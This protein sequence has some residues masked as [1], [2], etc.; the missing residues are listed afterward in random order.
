M[1][2]ISEEKLSELVEK[3]VERLANEGGRETQ[4][5]KTPASVNPPFGCDPLKRGERTQSEQGAA[6]VGGMQGAASGSGARGGLGRGVFSDLDSAVSSAQRAFQSYQGMGLKG[7]FA[8]IA[9]MR[10]RAHR[11]VENI[12]RMAVEETGLGR[13]DQKLIK[14]R[15]V[16]DKTPGPEI[17]DPWAQTGD[18]G[19]MIEEYAP[20]GIIGAIAPTTNPT[21]TVICNAIG[22]LAAGNAVIFNAH[23]SAKKVSAYTVQFLNEAIVSAG[24]PENLICCTAEP[25]IE[26][27]QQLMRHPGIRLLVVT[28]GPGVVKEAMNSGK[29]VIAAGPGNPPAVVDDSADLE[30]AAEGLVKGIS[31]DNN[32]V[33]TAEKEIIA[34]ASIADE[35]KRAMARYGAY[36]VKGDELTRLEKLIVVDGHPNKKF[37]GKDA[38]V[39]LKEIGVNAPQNTLIAYAEV[40]E[41]HPFVQLELLTPVTGLVRVRNVDDAIA[42]AVRCEH[43]NGHT[44]C[45]YSRNIAALHAMACVINTSIFTKNAPTYAGLGLG[46]EGY[47]SFTISSPTGEGLT[48]ARHFSRRRRCTLKDYFRIV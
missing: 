38:A 46:G 35:L 10:E 33:C 31:L 37:V 26:L 42:M 4:L 18:D 28:G 43:G 7:R 24:G 13:Y 9:A 30:Q 6:R 17:L 22:M 15:L 14:N 41:N 36:E 45:M 27:A 32:I 11:E 44:A 40:P 19:L 29:K 12:S 3:V 8:V 2:Y 20:F 25:T 23:P 39:I 48:N 1:P 21:E 5:R 34:V 47:T 16:I